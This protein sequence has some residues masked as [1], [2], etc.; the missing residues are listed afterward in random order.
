MTNTNPCLL[1]RKKPKG[2]SPLDDFH[3]Q[4][5]SIERF[6]GELLP[7]DPT[8]YLQKA[9]VRLVVARTELRLRN[10]VDLRVFG[11]PRLGQQLLHSVKAKHDRQDTL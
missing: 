2:L 4:D 11:G 10:R 7:V 8:D 1:D 9:A 6:W 5:F 3:R